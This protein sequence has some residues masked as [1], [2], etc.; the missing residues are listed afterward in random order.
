MQFKF[1]CFSLRMPTRTPPSNCV[2]AYKMG[3]TPLSVLV[4]SAAFKYVG[5]NGRTMPIENAS[6]KAIIFTKDS[7]DWVHDIEKAGEA[8]KYLIP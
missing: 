1:P 5:N 6:R 8:S 2:T 7:A 3:N 4:A